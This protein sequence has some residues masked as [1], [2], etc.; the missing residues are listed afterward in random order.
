MDRNVIITHHAYERAKQRFG[1][2]S[3]A[4]QLADRLS[5]IRGMRVGIAMGVDGEWYLRIPQM[6]MKLVM[7]GHVVKTIIRERDDI[8]EA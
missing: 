1:W 8:S 4:D 7:H 6:Q 3:T 2:A 5:A